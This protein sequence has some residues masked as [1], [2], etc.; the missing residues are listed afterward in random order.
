MDPLRGWPARSACTA[1]ACAGERAS[2]VNIVQPVADP[3]EA[4]IGGYTDLRLRS[5][6]QYPR[7]REGAWKLMAKGLR[8]SGRRLGMM[9][10]EALK[11]TH[12]EEIDFAW[13]LAD[14]GGLSSGKKS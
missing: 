2:A 11:R 12:S 5:G 3:E 8:A 13:E 6:F 14:A 4:Q 1:C 7:L 9:V 10:E